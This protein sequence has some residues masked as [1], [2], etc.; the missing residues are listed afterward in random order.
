MDRDSCSGSGTV[1]PVECMVFITAPRQRRADVARIHYYVLGKL[2][3]A[4][5]ERRS[6]MPCFSQGFSLTESSDEFRVACGDG[7]LP[8]CSCLSR[9]AYDETQSGGLNTQRSYTPRLYQLP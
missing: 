4:R 1:Y 6:L 3:K 8:F 9:E 5:Y 2:W 7:G